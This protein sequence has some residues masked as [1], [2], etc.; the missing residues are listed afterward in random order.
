MRAYLFL[1]LS[2]FAA[3][4]TSDDTT[5][6]PV[7]CSKVTGTDTFTVG[8]EK[9][10]VS[11]MVDYRLMSID[12]A[13]EPQRGDNTWIV[14]INAMNN[15]V[16]GAP[17]DGATI[18]VTPFMPAHQHGTPINA[19]VTPTGDPGTYKLEPVNLWM[20]GVWQTTITVT[21]NGGA[22]DKAIYTFCL[23]G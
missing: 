12:P 14:Q 23:P 20:P 8:L 16:V 10:G 9:M 5:D 11:G 15:S 21:P 3:C 18:V 17:I 22:A 19:V 2:C 13:P 7:D 1:G 6:P 4:G